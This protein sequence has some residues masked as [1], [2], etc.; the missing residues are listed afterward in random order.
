VEGAIEFEFQ[1]LPPRFA[2]P[3]VPEKDLFSFHSVKQ[4]EILQ[5]MNQGERNIRVR[6]N[7]YWNRLWVV[8][9][10]CLVRHI[11]FVF[12][13]EVWDEALAWRVL[14]CFRGRSDHFMEEP[15][16][17]GAPSLYRLLKA[18]EERFTDSMRLEA[19][20]ER[21]MRSGCG[22]LRDRVFGLVGLANDVDPL[23]SSGSHR[24]YKKDTGTHPRKDL[25]AFWARTFAWGLLRRV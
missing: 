6:Y 15:G 17:I 24:D 8:Q 11:G 5:A 2:D 13:A 23:C 14:S 10:V 9:E 16:A 25:S 1:I 21:F 18:R 4:S 12:G 19:L 22:E 20:I 3:A 7:T